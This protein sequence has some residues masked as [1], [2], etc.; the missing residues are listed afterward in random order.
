MAL[1]A[2]HDHEKRLPGTFSFFVIEPGAGRHHLVILNQGDPMRP[3]RGLSSPTLFVLSLFA[4]SCGAEPGPA[5]RSIVADTEAAPLS[6]GPSPI[7][8]LVPAPPRPVVTTDRKQHLLYELL[9]Q[10]VSAA[11]V[12]LASVA[13]FGDGARAPLVRYEGDSLAAVF[14]AAP[15]GTGPLA[16]GQ[17][18]VVF[19]DVAL[20]TTARLPCRLSNRLATTDVGGSA[21]H[22]STVSAAV[23]DERPALI[24]PPLR[25]DSFGD[26]NGCCSP[27]NNP[28]RTSLLAFPDGIFLAERYAIDFVRVDVAADNP[29]AHGDPTKNE[30]Y[31]I[32]GADVLAVTDGLIVDVRDGVAENVPVGSLPP[33]SIAASTGNYVV[34]ALDD[35]RFAL[36]AHLQPGSLLVRPGDR[37][38]R[39]D[40]LG[41]VGNTGNSTMPH[42][43]FHVMDRPAPDD[44]NGLP[45]VFDHFQLEASIDLNAADPQLVVV[46]APQG[47]RALLPMNGD[48]LGF[49]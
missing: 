13:V 19:V 47:R 5:P 6:A 17:L 36:Y 29:F 31:L 21:P 10:N 7:T 35:H 27:V 41:L 12:E 22:T 49:P 28:H 32:F 33:Y 23:I 26:L 3:T 40:V 8:V 34:E 15:N 38:S 30:S 14:I 18:G 43:H 24:S 1:A 20:P 37:V 11:P 45:Y 9:L 4:V 39:G 48:I 25:G 42:L 46:P 44:S 16:P 2:A